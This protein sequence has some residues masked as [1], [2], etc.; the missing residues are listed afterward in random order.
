MFPPEYTGQYS[1]NKL[2]IPTGMHG[3]SCIF[4]ANLTPFSPQDGCDEPPYYQEDVT[5]AEISTFCTAT[6]YERDYSNAV[7]DP[8]S[9][10]ADSLRRRST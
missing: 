10:R 7:A 8:T 1:D 2:M 4:W 6:Q 9:V 3:P 5:C